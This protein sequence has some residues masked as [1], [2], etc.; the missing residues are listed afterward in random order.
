MEECKRER[1]DGRWEKEGDRLRE[2]CGQR[3]WEG[4]KSGKAGEGQSRV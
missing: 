1:E 2:G 4:R 3:N